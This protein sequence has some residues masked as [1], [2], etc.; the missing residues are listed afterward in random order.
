[1]TTGA[2]TSSGGAD[3]IHAKHTSASIEAAV[4]IASM[5]GTAHPTKCGR[6]WST[7]RPDRAYAP[8]ATSSIAG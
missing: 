6:T 4:W 7:G 3:G 8:S 2:E 5:S 1:M